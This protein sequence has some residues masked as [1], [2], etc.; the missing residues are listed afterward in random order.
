MRKYIQLI[1]HVVDPDDVGI[2][3]ARFCFFSKGTIVFAIKEG[4]RVNTDDFTTVRDVV[5]SV[6]FNKRR[7]ADAL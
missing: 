1:H 2:N 3:L 6:A 5:E 4:F 7:G